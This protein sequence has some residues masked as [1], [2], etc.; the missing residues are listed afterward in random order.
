MADAG[1]AHAESTRAVASCSSRRRKRDAGRATALPGHRRDGCIAKRPVGE[2]PRAAARTWVASAAGGGFPSGAR[3]LG[4]REWIR[5]PS[6]PPGRGQSRREG[7][8]SW[9]SLYDG[10][11]PVALPDR[12]KRTTPRCRSDSRYGAHAQC[13]VPPFGAHERRVGA[14]SQAVADRPE[15]TA[16]TTRSISAT[17]SSS[18]RA[19]PLRSACASASGASERAPPAADVKR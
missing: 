5:W 13:R 15:T 11:G 2:P 4:S 17:D 9:A 19:A 10:S 7:Q 1:H 6:G 3:D 16:A 18:A 14:V 12:R 8:P